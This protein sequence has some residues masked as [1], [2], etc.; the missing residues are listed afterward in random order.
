PVLAASLAN[1]GRIGVIYRDSI[2]HVL[3]VFP[4]LFQVLITVAYGVPKDEGGKLDFKIDLGDP[5]PCSVGFL[6][7]TQ[8][9]SPADATVRD[10]PYDMYCKVPHNDRSEERRVGKESIAGCVTASQS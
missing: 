5:P 3:V 9:R 2:E 8:V 7:P 10:L 4:A 6:P 1:F